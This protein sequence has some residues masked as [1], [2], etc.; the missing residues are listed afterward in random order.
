MRVYLTGT[1]ERSEKYILFLYTIHNNLVSSKQLS[2]V[3]LELINSRRVE[4]V[5]VQPVDTALVI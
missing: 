3:S 2:S 5:E 1:N 4:S